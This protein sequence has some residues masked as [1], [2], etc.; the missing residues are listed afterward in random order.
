M[1]GYTPDFAASVEHINTF[2]RLMLIGFVEAVASENVAAALLAISA[3]GFFFSSGSCFRDTAIWNLGMRK[4][5]I[6]DVS[7]FLD[8]QTL[9]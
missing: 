3:S 1:P 8:L 2:A 9:L 5:A 6:R 7:I 4:Q